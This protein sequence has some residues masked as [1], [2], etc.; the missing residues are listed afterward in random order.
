MMESFRRYLIKLTCLG[1]HAVRRAVGIILVKSRVRVLDIDTEVINLVLNAVGILHFQVGMS[2][3][4][5]DGQLNNGFWGGC[6]DNCVTVRVGWVDVRRGRGRICRSEWDV[7]RVAGK[8]GG[9]V[10]GGRRGSR[11]E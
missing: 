3:G 6:E 7:R 10:T 2:L 9:A 11:E 8:H 4:L 5:R 1:V